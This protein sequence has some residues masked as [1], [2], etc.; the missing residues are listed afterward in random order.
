MLAKLSQVAP[1]PGGPCA[2]AALA[3]LWNLLAGYGGLVSVGQQAYVGLGAYFLFA[4]G[5]LFGVP[6]LAELIGP[7]LHKKVQE[8][9]EMML[10]AL[11]REAEAETV[12]RRRTA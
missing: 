8:N 6:P 3:S 2:Y 10:A 4:C 12:L 1:Q 9:S 11:K 5:I 7:T